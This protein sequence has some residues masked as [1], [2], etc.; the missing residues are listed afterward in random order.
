MVGCLDN[1]KKG[2]T[3]YDINTKVHVAR[4]GFGEDNPLWFKESR[5][6]Q[7]KTQG[8]IRVMLVL[9]WFCAVVLYLQC[10]GLPPYQRARREA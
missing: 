10:S 5:P 1:S 7:D 3:R 6:R 4:I 9:L 2:M 8:K